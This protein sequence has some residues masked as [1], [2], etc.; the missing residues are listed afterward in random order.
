MTLV[1]PALDSSPS[2]PA[3]LPAYTAGVA[4]LDKPLRLDSGQILN[5]VDIAYC[6][7]GRLNATRSNAVLICHA[8]TGDQY[9]AATNPAT[10]RPGWWPTMIGP[11]KTIDPDKHFIISSNVLGGCMG[12]TGPSSINP[13]TG[14]PWGDRKSTR[15]NSSH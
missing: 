8:L 12:S 4:C 11:G 1:I 14:A 7:Q 2:D 15:L 9:A 6:T 3:D 13:D 5:R 10:G